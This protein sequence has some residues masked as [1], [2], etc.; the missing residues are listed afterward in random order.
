MNPPPYEKQLVMNSTPEPVAEP[1]KTQQEPQPRIPFSLSL[2]QGGWS[3]ELIYPSGPPGVALSVSFEPFEIGRTT[4]GRALDNNGEFNT[5]SAQFTYLS[6]GDYV[7]MITFLQIYR[8]R[9]S[10]QVW[11]FVGTV[12][13]DNNQIFGEWYDSPQDG[14]QRTGTFNLERSG[15]PSVQCVN[16]LHT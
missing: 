14:R 7:G 4:N 12:R 8:S 11:F 1:V 9:Y 2:L 15:S 6:T 16:I 5:Q 3:G 13:K 10:G